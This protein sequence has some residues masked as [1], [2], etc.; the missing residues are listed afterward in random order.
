MQCLLLLSLRE[1]M[2]PRW[3]NQ[4]VI[5]CKL[6]RIYDKSLALFGSV[7]LLRSKAVKTST[8]N[9]A[10]LEIAPVKFFFYYV[11]AISMWNV[12]VFHLIHSVCKQ[13]MLSDIRKNVPQIRRSVAY[14][15]YGSVKT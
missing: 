13:S 14:D 12:I 3:T 10:I 8:P 1:H 9:L 4:F 2:C 11:N 5:S 7:N 6:G 15:V